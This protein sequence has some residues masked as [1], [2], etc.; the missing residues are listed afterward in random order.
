MAWVIKTTHL[1]CLINRNE[2]IDLMETKDRKDIEQGYQIV[3]EIVSVMNSGNEMS[4]LDQYPAIREWLET[5][6]DA[7]E[8]IDMMCS[9]DDFAEMNRQYSES[10]SQR[11]VLF[12]EIT[13]RKQR[14]TILLRV[15]IG[16]VA[17]AASIVIAFGILF[18]SGVEET[19][20]IVAENKRVN[21]PTLIYSNGNVEQL[22]GNTELK[23][24]GEV[25]GTI[26]DHKLH[27]K[28]RNRTRTE[29]F[30]TLSV[31]ERQKYNLILEDGTEII[32]SANSKL[33]FPSKFADDRRYVELKGEAYFKVAKDGKPFVVNVNNVLVKV[34]GTQFNIDGSSPDIKTTLIQGSVGVEYG[35]TEERR[36]IKIVPG[37]CMTVNIKE[38]T[39]KVE[40]DYSIEKFKYWLDGYFMFSNDQLV[41]LLTDISKWY[42][43]EFLYETPELRGR[44]INASIHC[45]LPLS[46]VIEMI[47]TVTNVK[48]IKKGENG[49]IVKEE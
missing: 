20:K 4:E 17:V 46:E 6:E 5:D 22:T 23:V 24:D 10:S 33:K 48:F 11:S 34:Y 42:G 25:V 30:E 39:H 29:V 21:V 26:R 3:E 1:I 13:R 35:T 28:D 15:R 31:P 19:V 37:E 2:K 7:H 45:E 38:N 12:H 14:K 16:A 32:V 47:Q 43:V 9:R 44:I 8:V 27:Y 40:V 41:N 18:N 36:E 49:Y